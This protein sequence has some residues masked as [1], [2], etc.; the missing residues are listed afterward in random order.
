MKKLPEATSAAEHLKQ[1][2][3][4][5]LGAF[6]SGAGIADGRPEPMTFE[7]AVHTLWREI[8]KAFYAQWPR[9]AKNRVQLRLSKESGTLEELLG[10]LSLCGTWTVRASVRGTTVAH[11]VGVMNRKTN[12]ITVLGFLTEKGWTVTDLALGA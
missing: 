1:V 11:A 9:D 3:Q 2:V 8:D 10:L 6:Q 12:P 7:L 4:T 5:V